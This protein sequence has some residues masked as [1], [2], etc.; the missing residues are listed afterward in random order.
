MKKNTI[1]H[2]LIFS[3]ELRRAV[4]RARRLADQTRRKHLVIIYGGKP[5]CI[6][7]QRLRQMVHQHYF[8]HGVTAAMI[9]ER[10]VCTAMPR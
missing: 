7:K 9:E 6:S 4:K 10:A 1:F 2:K 8:R 3:W 5:V